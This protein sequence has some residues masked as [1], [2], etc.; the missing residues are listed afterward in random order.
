MVNI[1]SSKFGE[2]LR[3]ILDH[4]TGSGNRQ[5]FAAVK[6]VEFVIVLVGE[7][8]FP[9]PPLLFN[10]LLNQNAESVGTAHLL[11][12]GGLVDQRRDADLREC[13]QQD[14]GLFSQAMLR[15]VKLSG[16]LS[17]NNR[18]ADFDQNLSVITVSQILG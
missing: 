2:V 7:L 14:L 3:S 1:G 8:L 13:V 16:F 11:E 10:V 12:A 9:F 15:A 5:P 6:A 17:A 4:R 18:A